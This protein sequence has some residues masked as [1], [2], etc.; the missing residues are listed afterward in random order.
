MA[1]RSAAKPS[2][3]LLPG[4]IPRRGRPRSAGTVAGQRPLRAPRP[5]RARNCGVGGPD[6][7]TGGISARAVCTEDEG[8]GPVPAE[9]RN[10]LGGYLPSSP[11]ESVLHHTQSMAHRPASAS[12]TAPA[13]AGTKLTW[14]SPKDKRR[15]A[16]GR[17]ALR[18]HPAGGRQLSCPRSAGRDCAS[19][20]RRGAR[21]DSRGSTRWRQ[22]RGRRPRRTG[23]GCVRSRGGA[24]HDA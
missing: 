11:G 6:R 8:G 9:A 1:I 5:T 16:S 21:S 24:R 7:H 3:S 18:S 15:F 22:G 13:N 10:V 14:H 20:R 4:D 23:R 12:G 19:R 2:C 17:G